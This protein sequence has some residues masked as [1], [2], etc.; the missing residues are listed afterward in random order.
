VTVLIE[1]KFIGY[2][3]ESYYYWLNKI[4]G[5]QT[6]AFELGVP[7]VTVPPGMIIGSPMAGCVVAPLLTEIGL[8]V[9]TDDCAKKEWLENVRKFEKIPMVFYLCRKVQKEFQ[10]L[11]KSYLS[12]RGS[13]EGHQQNYIFVWICVKFQNFLITFL[14]FHILS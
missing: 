4:S 11:L 5:V 1:T 14:L 7:G 2:L 12:V 6:F 10:Y 8:N 13:D 9:V 3:S